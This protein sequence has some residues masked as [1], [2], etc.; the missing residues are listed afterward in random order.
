MKVIAKE[1]ERVKKER[2]Q[3]YAVL[4]NRMTPN[5]LERNAFQLETLA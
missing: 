2:V 1:G 3:K 5:K 4:I